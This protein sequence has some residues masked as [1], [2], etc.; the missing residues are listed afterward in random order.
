MTDFFN[1]YDNPP[2]PQLPD[3]AEQESLF[4]GFRIVLEGQSEREGNNEAGV[5]AESLERAALKQAEELRNRV[6]NLLKN[7]RLRRNT[8][9]SAPN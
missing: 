8:F 6:S 1:G 5:K 9:V 3:E 7:S 2:E 4:V